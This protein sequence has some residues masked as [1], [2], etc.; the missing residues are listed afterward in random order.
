MSKTYYVT[1]PIYY[2]SGNP[3]VGHAYCSIMADTLAR[4]HRLLGEDVFFLTGT[5]EH[6]QKV[7]ENAAKAG[8]TPKQYV[9]LL[10]IAFKAL[11]AKL[12]ISYDGYIR[13]TDPLHQAAVQ[14]IFRQLYDQGDIYKKDYEGHYCVPC[15]A[16]WTEHQI[17]EGNLCPDCGR[18]VTWLKEESYYFRASKY[19]DRLL[20]YIEDNPDFIQPV[21]RTNEMVNNFLKP[22]LNDLCVSRTSVDWGIPVTF[23]PKHTIYVWIDALPNYITALGY[24]SDDDSLL[25][26]FWPAD[27]HLVGKEIIRFHTIIWPIILMALGLPLPKQVFGHGWLLYDNE[28]MSKSKGNV[29]DPNDIIRDYG[30]DPLRYYLLAKVPTGNDGNFTTELIANIF[31][32]DLANDLGNLLSR[33]IAMQER[34]FA[35]I[36]QTPSERSALDAGLIELAEATPAAVNAAMLK[37]DFNAALAAIWKLIGR[38]NKYIDETLPWVLAKDASQKERL[39]TVLYHL[40][41]VLRIT[42]VLLQPFMPETSPRIF[43]QLGLMGRSPL[44]TWQSIQ[45]FG[46]LPAGTKL[47][48]GESLFP[49]IEKENPDGS[50]GKKAKAVNQSKK[51]QKQEKLE[52][53]LQQMTEENPIAANETQVAEAEIIETNVL[54]DQKPL[55]TVDDFAKIDF[56]IAEI[57]ACEKVAKADRLLKLRVRIGQTERVIVSGIAEYYTPEELIGRQVCVVANLAPH[58][59]RGIESNG[60]LLAASD[61]AH[62]SVIL[63]QPEKRAQNGWRVK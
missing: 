5:D 60:M 24:G 57:V 26:R 14:K 4:F 52:E 47:R 17:K 13:T 63:L 18:P 35:G 62:T 45:N 59:F 39:A 31:N 55:I 36:V 16:Y 58:T 3:H 12:N 54:A 25:Q 27:L 9:D 51:N 49:R 44:Q 19:A 46:G 43:F 23:D 33:T 21:S 32:T 20:Q 61:D 56:R 10:D 40:A 48:K 28:K 41:E 7:E 42:A 29:V 53:G 8:L 11:W 1:T 30:T 50:L 37:N 2:T 34:Y 38:S 22:G 15:E 6:G